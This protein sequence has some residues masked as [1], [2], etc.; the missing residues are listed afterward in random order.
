MKRRRIYK[1]G[2]VDRRVKKEDLRGWDAREET[3][4]TTLASAA[5]RA[6]RAAGI[7]RAVRRGARVVWGGAFLVG[8]AAY[9]FEQD[10]ATVGRNA[11]AASLSCVITMVGV[12]LWSARKQKS[13]ARDRR[14]LALSAAKRLEKR[15]SEQNLNVVAAVDFCGENASNEKELSADSSALRNA[16]V[17][18]ATRRFREFASTLDEAELNAALTGCPSERLRKIGKQGRLCALGALVNLAIWGIS[19]FNEKWEGGRKTIDEI[20]WADCGN[21]VGQDGQNSGNRGNSATAEEERAGDGSEGTEAGGGEE[22]ALEAQ[23]TRGVEAISLLAL[24]TWISELAQNAEIA[25][26]LKAELERAVEGEASGTPVDATSFLQLTRELQ[27]NLTRLG[28]GLVAQTRRLSEAARRERREVEERLGGIGCDG[29][30]EGKEEERR[31]NKIGGIGENDGRKEKAQGIAGKE[32]AALLASL[33]LEKFETELRAAGGIGDAASLGLSRVLRSDSPKA[34]QEVMLTAAARV[35]E[36]G[37]ALRRE[38]TAARIFAESWRFDATSQHWRSLA[39]R[40]AQENRTLLARFAG[41]LT[42]GVERTSEN[43]EVLE[44]AKRRFNALWRETQASEK[45]SVAIVKR[46]R[47]RLQNEEAREFRE[48][49]AQ[50]ASRLADDVCLGDVKADGA[51]GGWLNDVATMGEKRWLEIAQSVEKNRFGYAAERFDEGD[52]LWRGERPAFSRAKI[53]TRTQEK[54][55]DNELAVNGKIKRVEVDEEEKEETLNDAESGTTNEDRRFSALAALLTLGVDAKTG[56]MRNE[57]IVLKEDVAFLESGGKGELLSPRKEKTKEADAA[58]GEKNEL[59]FKE[60]NA[61]ND[62]TSS[63]RREEKGD[64]TSEKTAINDDKR[65]GWDASSNDGVESDVENG[66]RD[67]DN[68]TGGEN[69][70]NATGGASGGASEGEALELETS[71]NKAFIGETPFEARR[72]FEETSAPKVLPEYAEKIRLYRRRI[73]K[74]QR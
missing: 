19:E 46:L 40:A 36:W 41:R 6:T 7:E 14:A 26:S 39:N 61:D 2:K 9:F 57:Q 31:K 34:R 72:R 22:T 33:R 29:K 43:D 4:L 52:A 10:A 67:G 5:A 45:E 32:V 30:M 53:A 60:L 65:L 42:A 37:A 49:V 74:E 63:K 59:I 13:R 21:F 70:E 20:K 16:T 56:T 62:A 12:F 8:A 69:G 3:I 15:F 64:K 54:N 44:E 11:F 24:E 23:E 55:N 71:A 18:A 48:F 17:V 50:D 51:V 66:K 68:E 25:E 1:K 35:G 28:T 27:T 58:E 73:G 47:E 38:E